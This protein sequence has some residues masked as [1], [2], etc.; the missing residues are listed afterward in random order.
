MKYELQQSGEI[1]LAKSLDRETLNNHLL[2]V[3]ASDR[4]EPTL[5]ASATVHIDVLDVQ[6]N[7]PIFE[8]DS[9]FAE[10]REDAPVRL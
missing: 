4:L 3:T 6:D 5:T 7:S 8:R 1:R 2:K 10:I 9:Y